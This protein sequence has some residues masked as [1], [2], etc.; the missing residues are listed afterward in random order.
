VGGISA[1]AR[2]PLL[3]INATAFLQ[4][5]TVLHPHLGFRYPDI[6]LTPNL[7]GC[8]YERLEGFLLLFDKL[9]ILSRHRFA[10]F[11]ECSAVL[12]QPLLV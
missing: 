7:P 3:A 9:L 12:D 6:V 1:H 8:L 10:V 5:L 11:L 4:I 2:T